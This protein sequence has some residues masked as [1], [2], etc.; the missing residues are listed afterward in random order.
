M[1]CKRYEKLIGL[2]IEEALSPGEAKKLEEHFSR[3]AR[4]A[5]HI[6]LLQAVSRLI[7]RE[8]GQQAPV[9]EDF[10]A[11]WRGIKSRLPANCKKHILNKIA[12]ARSQIFWEVL[13]ERPLIP[14]AALFLATLVISL[15]AKAIGYE[16]EVKELFLLLSRRGF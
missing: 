10:E 2:F 15:A 8:L 1:S 14:V 6:E 5:G 7:I 13:T 16:N 11:Y 4:C 3:C 9:K 12:H